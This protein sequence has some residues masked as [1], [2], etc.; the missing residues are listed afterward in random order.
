MLWLGLRGRVKIEALEKR[1]EELEQG[2]R[3]LELEM[4]NAVDR[5]HGLAKRMQGRRGGR[6][7]NGEAKGDAEPD[8]PE[9]PHGFFSRHSA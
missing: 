2:F 1:C 9:T 8:S 3:A 7:P 6:P 4:T 5:L